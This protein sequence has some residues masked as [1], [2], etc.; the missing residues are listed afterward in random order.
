MRRNRARKM[1]TRHCA[2]LLPAKAG[3]RQDSKARFGGLF[4]SRPP[5]KMKHGVDI[6]LNIVWNESVAPLRGNGEMGWAS[7][8]IAAKSFCHLVMPRM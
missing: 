5:R 3:Q 4:H 2:A 6:Q 8:A 7:Y 1:R